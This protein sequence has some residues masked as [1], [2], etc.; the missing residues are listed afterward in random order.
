M[1][2]ELLEQIYTVV[3]QILV[4]RITTYGRTAKMTD[5]AS[6][7]MDGSAMLPLPDGHQLPW[8]RVI[9]A[10]LKGTELGGAVRQRDKLR[11]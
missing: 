10:S 6:W 2:A 3:A 7:L 11:R 9:K 4:R 5:G 1:R 8:H